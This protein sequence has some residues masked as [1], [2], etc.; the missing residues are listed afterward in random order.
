RRKKRK[1]NRVYH[2]LGTNSCYGY[3]HDDLCD[4][5]SLIL[6]GHQF[7]KIEEFLVLANRN[8]VGKSTFYRYQKLI[9]FLC[10]RIYVER[11]TRKTEKT[12]L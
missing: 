6:G 8:G 2:E 10:S 3:G 11:R 4:T 1:R 5:A 9:R 7:E 12:Y